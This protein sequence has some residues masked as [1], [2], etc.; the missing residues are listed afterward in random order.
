MK[1]AF[2]E[3]YVHKKHMTLDLTDPNAFR[4]SIRYDPLTK[5]GSVLDVVQIVTGYASRDVSQEY[6]K[7]RDKFPDLADK[8]AYIKFQ[9]QGQRPTP[10]AHLST[11][12]EIAWLCPGK[13]AKEFRRTGAVT[14]CRALGGDLSLV[15]EIRRRHAVVTAE[16]QDAF[17]AGTGITVAEANGQTVMP[18][19]P[20]EE[21]TLRLSNDRT[22]MEIVKEKVAWLKEMADNEE[23][24]RHRMFIEDT[25][26][27][28][29]MRYANM[30]TDGLATGN[31]VEVRQPLSISGVAADMG[32]TKLGAGQLSAIGKVAASMYREMYDKNP[33]KHPQFVD[34]ATRNV[35]SYTSE[36]RDILTE[37]VHA[38]LG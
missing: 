33:P 13:R 17:L 31:C 34:G 2:K 11:L 36:D 24:S 4:D 37:A 27:N 6:A 35:N 23:D 5:R 14:M 1:L 26:K 20:E 25:R 22:E 9:G 16:E 19:N 10:V 32:F 29:F 7:V 18:R 15:E 21:R 38:V 3:V 30:V 8:V 12:L 28:M